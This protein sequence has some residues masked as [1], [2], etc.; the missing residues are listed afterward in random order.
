MEN[1]ENLE[2]NESSLKISP[3]GDFFRGYLYSLCFYI[4]LACAL[5][6]LTVE[7]CFFS[8]T[9]VRNRLLKHDVYYEKLPKINQNNLK[10]IKKK[11]KNSFFFVFRVRVFFLLL[12]LCRWIA[13][14]S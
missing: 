2:K 14:P 9:P 7:K 4:D 8:P 1:Y 3:L 5:A 13:R 6:I 11:Q 12:V 10:S